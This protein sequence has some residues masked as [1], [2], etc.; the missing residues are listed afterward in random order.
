MLISATSPVGEFEFLDVAGEDLATAETVNYY[1]D[2]LQEA[3][4]I[5]FL[6]DPLQLPEVRNLLVGMMALPPSNAAS[7]AVIW[8]NLKEVVGPVGSR[9]NPNQKV[10]V[11][12]SKFDA[13]TLAMS[14]GNFAFS[15]ALDSAMALNRDPYASNPSQPSPG[16]EKRYAR[17]PEI[18]AIICRSIVGKNALDCLG[19]RKVNCREGKAGDNG[20]GQDG[21]KRRSCFRPALRLAAGN[22]QQY[23]TNQADNCR[24]HTRARASDQ[25]K[26]Y[27]DYRDGGRRKLPRVPTIAWCSVRPCGKNG[28]HGEE[29]GQENGSVVSVG[30]ETHGAA[31][32]CNAIKIERPTYAARQLKDA[33]YP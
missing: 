25:N 24:K 19:A 8:E 18:C 11:T 15:E 32:I 28:Q 16:A 3:D 26:R 33:D 17:G 30:K 2:A 31:I 6:F 27:Q 14:S 7:P 22:V 23:P 20:D 21:Y 5:I 4:L 12:M 9:K 13:L 29:A 10:A 1:R